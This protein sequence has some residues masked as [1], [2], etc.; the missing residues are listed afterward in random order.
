MDNRWTCCAT[1]IFDA[2]AHFVS[3]YW[4]LCP[5]ALVK[6]HTHTK[7]TNDWCITTLRRFSVKS[8]KMQ[9]RQGFQSILEA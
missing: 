3:S 1:W 4:D 9:R 5:S 8:I 6:K 7:T 2:D